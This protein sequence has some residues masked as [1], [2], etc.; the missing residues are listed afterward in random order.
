M[1][2][3]KSS[4]QGIRS[5]DLYASRSKPGQQLTCSSPILTLSFDIC[6]DVKQWEASIPFFNQFNDSAKHYPFFIQQ[7]VY[8][9]LEPTVFA[10]QGFYPCR[11][12][13]EDVAC[14]CS[15]IPQFPTPLIEKT[16]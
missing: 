16:A 11:G 7:V 3:A 15:L 8:R 13:N 12:I 6:Q 4:D 10:S 14:T 5:W 9:L 1:S 2:P